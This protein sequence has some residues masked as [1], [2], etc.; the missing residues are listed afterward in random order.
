MGKQKDMSINL[1]YNV[2]QIIPCLE[3]KENVGNYSKMFQF[4]HLCY[5]KITIPSS[6]AQCYGVSLQGALQQQIIHLQLVLENAALFFVFC[7]ISSSLV[8]SYWL[9]FV[10][11]TISIFQNQFLVWSLNDY[12]A[13]LELCSHTSRM[14]GMVPPSSLFFLWAECSQDQLQHC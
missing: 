6:Y 9:S 12:F 5:C 10:I 2:I 14:P 8:I 13:D 3:K 11:I 7:S 4:S 1:L